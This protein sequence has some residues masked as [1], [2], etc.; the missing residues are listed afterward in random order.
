MA[1]SY[2][3]CQVNVTGA[4][5]GALIPGDANI[6]T[7][8]GN[9]YQVT[10]DTFGTF[11]LNFSTIDIPTQGVFESF[12]I[13]VFANKTDYGATTGFI[14]L[15]VNPIQTI[16]DANKSIV[17]AYLNEVIDLKVNYTIEDSNELISGAN[18]SVEWEGASNIVSVAD[19]F[20]I[21]LD[22]KGLSTS[23]YTAL[24]K[25]EHIGYANAFK[26]VTIIISEQN[27]NLKVVINSLEVGENSLVE[28]SYNKVI[29][30]SC[31]AY[32]ALEQIYLS[33][34]TITFINEQYEQSLVEYD[35]SWF[36]TSI[37]IST[38]TF[39]LGINYV[40]I[41]FQQDNYTTTTF[42]FQILVNQIEFDVQTIDFQ[43]SI[44]V[45]TGEKIQIRINLTEFGTMNFIEN[46]TISYSWDLAGDELFRF[47]LPIYGRGASGGI[48]MYDITR[49]SSLNNF[50]NWLNLFKQ[51]VSGNETDIPIIMVGNKIDLLNMRTVS[52][53]DAIKS[54]RYHNI[55][56][57]I[58]CSAKTGENVSLIFNALT[59]A[60]MKKASFI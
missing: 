23:H 3:I 37:L 17:N 14:T 53:E 49:A 60:I 33:G 25:L 39:S 2:A 16:A 31:R 9:P 4:I 24:I 46:A 10:N 6:T 54:S 52:I 41:R 22:T 40:Y 50:D 15:I 19:G 58:E 29:T 55:L 32:A 44:E 26:S 43:D 7:D 5:S 20:I 11:T 56:D 45:N 48:F 18:C 21:S 38:S 47:L 12:T 28:T 34:G 36:S 35:N 27:V 42:S 51:D 13:T 57:F 59:L 1:N 30:L 8:W